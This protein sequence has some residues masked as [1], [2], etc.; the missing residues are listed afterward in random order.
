MTTMTAEHE[1]NHANHDQILAETAAAR[2]KASALLAGLLEAK[3]TTERELAQYQRTDLLKKVTGRSALDNAIE[4]T[5]R[6]IET[7]DRTMQRLHR[8]L[9]EDDLVIFE[10]R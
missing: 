3:A 9:G 8:E 7:L 1:S 5:R 2:E 6:M 10:D 4:S